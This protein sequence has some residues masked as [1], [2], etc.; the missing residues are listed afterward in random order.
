SLGNRA[1]VPERAEFALYVLA[2][3]EVDQLLRILQV[4]GFLEYG[5]GLHMHT[6]LIP[7]DGQR[8]AVFD[9]FEDARAPYGAEIGLSGRQH[10]HRQG[11]RGPELRN[12]GPDAR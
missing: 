1:A 11:A 2:Q 5:I 8:R 4:L 3:A 12:G 9:S 7:V 10:L 6:M